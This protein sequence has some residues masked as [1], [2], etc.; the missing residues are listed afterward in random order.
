MEFSFE[1]VQ[2]NSAGAGASLRVGEKVPDF[3]LA[4]SDGRLRR[5]SELAQSGPV[6]LVFYRGH[7]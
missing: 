5:L 2:G 3:E 1:T 4:D 7:W 6:V